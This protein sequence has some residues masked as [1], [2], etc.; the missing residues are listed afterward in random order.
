MVFSLTIPYRK[1]ITSIKH[2]ELLKIL[3]PYF[4]SNREGGYFI[5]ADWGPGWDDIVFDVHNK[6]V[7]INPNYSIV[8]IKEKFAA[9]R[10]YVFGITNEYYEIMIDAE[11]RSA[12]TCEECGRPGSPTTDTY[13][14]VTLCDWD[15][16]VRR[17]NIQIARIRRSPYILYWKIRFAINRW[18]LKRNGSAKNGIS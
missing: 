6:L 3:G 11:E 9:L 10:Y 17:I 12:V 16:N 4:G 1:P 7:K 2:E 14:V 13:W 18:R 5:G 15:R 8:Q